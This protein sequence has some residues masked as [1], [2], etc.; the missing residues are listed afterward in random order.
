MGRRPS[1]PRTAWAALAL[2]ACAAAAARLAAPPAADA[3]GARGGLALAPTGGGGVAGGAP[4]EM[5][6]GAGGD[7]GF[8]AFIR[9]AGEDPPD[10][11]VAVGPDHLVAVINHRIRIFAKAT[12]GVLRTTSLHAPFADLDVPCTMI[13]PRVIYD[14]DGHFWIT[15][16]AS[17]CLGC[18]PPP[19]CDH[20]AF[21]AIAVS[22]TPD[23]MGPWQPWAIDMCEFANGSGLWDQ[24]RVGVDDDNVYI[25]ANAGTQLTVLDKATL[26][27]GV[28][29]PVLRSGLTHWSPPNISPSDRLPPDIAGRMVFVRTS[30]A[31]DTV[32]LTAIRAWTPFTLSTI[33]LDVEPFGPTGD[34]L[35]QK[36][37]DRS[38]YGLTAGH[39]GVAHHAATDGL[40]VAHT[41]RTSDGSDRVVVRW[42]EIALGGWPGSAMPLPY[43]VQQ[44]QIDP[45]D[46]TSNAAAFMP[47]VTVDDHGT[48]AIVYEVTSTDEYISLWTAVRYPHDPPGV[49]GRRV[50][51]VTSGAPRSSGRWGDY[52]A[53]DP[54]PDGGR[55]FWAHHQYVHGAGETWRTWI[56]A[57][58]PYCAAD[59]DLGG[60]VD[61]ADVLEVLAQWGA[62]PAPCPPDVDGNGAVDFQ[63]L[64]R[65][66]AHFGCEYPDCCL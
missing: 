6:R 55:T 18:P 57:V 46:P 36:G 24:P 21:L 19:G 62:C 1:P 54:D 37:S 40:W 26:L 39:P 17:F 10:P 61:L 52:A 30:T 11:Y 3:P 33:A 31:F 9:A 50:R 51:H 44:G 23:P 25:N 14:D 12:G 28:G 63:D 53:I 65:V 64:L 2:L 29:D 5:A 22:R 60:I 47:A 38:F 56:Q 15:A 13:D 16:S 66:L 20:C 58:T 27:A 4:L 48:A 35:P 32:R 42:Y 41:A 8:D 45:P 43:V 49:F 7:P 34:D 59:V